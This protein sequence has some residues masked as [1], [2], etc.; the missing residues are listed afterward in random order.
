MNCDLSLR[1]GLNV[2]VQASDQTPICDATVTAVDGTYTETLMPLPG[3]DC[4]YVGAGERAGTYRIRAEKTGFMAAE[5][6]GVVVE[7][8]ECH[9]EGQNVELTLTST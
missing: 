1:F 2:T 8:G 4:A 5:R 9:V 3:G 7:D 6:A